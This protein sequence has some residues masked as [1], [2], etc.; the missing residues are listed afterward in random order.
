MT[1]TKRSEQTE[2]AYRVQVREALLTL[3]RIM[4]PQ[5][6][7]QFGAYKYE[8]LVEYAADFIDSEA[9][10]V[11]RPRAGGK[12]VNLHVDGSAGGLALDD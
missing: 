6:Q 8:D 5:N 12:Q 7:I 1:Q 4:D 3:L 11:G 2:R 9:E 10:A